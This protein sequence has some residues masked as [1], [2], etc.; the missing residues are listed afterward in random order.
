MEQREQVHWKGLEMFGGVLVSR[1]SL[2]CSETAPIVERYVGPEGE[3]QLSGSLSCQD[4]Q[5]V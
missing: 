3:L 5:N 2:P 1:F 4:S